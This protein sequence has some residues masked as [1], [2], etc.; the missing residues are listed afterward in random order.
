MLAAVA[1]AIMF[2]QI[3]QPA[4]PDTG[5]LLALMRLRRRRQRIQRLQRRKKLL[6]LRHRHSLLLIGLTDPSPAKRV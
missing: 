1:A 6:M 5:F 3:S 4:C 2:L